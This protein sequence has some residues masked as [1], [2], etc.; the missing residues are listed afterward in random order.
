MQAIL[1]H[2]YV[3]V[4]S[5]QFTL[6]QL[7]TR[8]RQRR[9][10]TI[11]SGSLVRLM[12]RGTKNIDLFNLPLREYLDIAFIAEFSRVALTIT[13]TCLLQTDHR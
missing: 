4:H 13:A 12:T 7:A 2:E 9:C 10:G 3:S 5:L 6:V 1:G 8:R 11:Q